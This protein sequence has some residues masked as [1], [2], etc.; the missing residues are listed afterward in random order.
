MG[1]RCELLGRCQ[2]AI[3]DLLLFVALLRPYTL[4]LAMW[5]LIE[6][7]DVAQLGRPILS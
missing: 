5:L 4:S 6:K 1:L 3:A 2:L 7:K